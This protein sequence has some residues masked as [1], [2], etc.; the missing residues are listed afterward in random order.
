MK[1]IQLTRPPSALK[2]GL[3]LLLA[4]K[5]SAGRIDSLPQISYQLPRTTL[6]SRHLERYRQVCGF[7]AAQGV[8]L[9][10]P[11]L[12]TAPLVMQFFISPECP[13]PALGTVHLANR[14]EQYAA[15]QCGDELRVEVA[16]G[17]LIAHPKGQMF[18]LEQRIYRDQALIWQATQSLLRVGVA[19]PRG[20]AYRSALSSAAAL[21]QCGQFA[22]EAAIGR[23]YGAVSG[24]LN[25]IHLTALS[26]K[27][28][29]FKRAIAHG[30]WTKARALALLLPE[31]QIDAATAS[32][33]FKRP[34]LLPGRVTLWRG[35][36]EF[37]VRDG[38]GRAPHLRGHLRLG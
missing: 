1:T 29:G 7:T 28:F 8:P 21:S 32:V 22:A 15:L 16:S 4:G 2:T 14:I 17:E 30:M 9:I 20:V 24:D 5:R 11:Q 12:L 6:D 3:Q 10:Y 34:L 18:T 23:R 13:W 36:G 31:Q 26:A 27:L 37:E 33:E 19:E 35:D 38:A 25:P